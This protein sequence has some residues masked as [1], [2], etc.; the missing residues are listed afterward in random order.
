MSIY[1][2]KYTNEASRFLVFDG[3]LVHYRDEG[4]G[5]V[6]L[7]IHGA[8]SS[9]HTF[10]QW[11]A[12][13][14]NSFRIIRIDLPGFG[15]SQ[16]RID[17]KYD[18][19]T[20]IRCLNTVLKLLDVE[21]CSVAGSSLGG[22]LAWEF[23]LEQPQKVD[24]LILIDSAGFLDEKSIPLPFRMARTPFVNKI[25]RYII[26]KNVLEVFLRQVYGDSSK[27]TPELV[28]R[29]YDLFSREGNPEAFF[30]L[31]NGKFKDN[32]HQLSHI[33]APTL[34]MWGEKDE[35]LPVA[36][37]YR[38][39]SEIPQARMIIYEDLGHIPMEEDPH[40]TAIDAKAF[41]LDITL[42]EAEKSVSDKSPSER[43]K[44]D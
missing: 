21:S 20:Y 43:T 8:F 41:L 3:T 34:I 33:K 25:V 26:K 35:W 37:G 31:V 36:N 2:Q 4:E 12:E 24:K 42:A 16:A 7:L 17:H 23:A 28:D 29:Y 27:I 15:L 40:H 14:K 10:D 39:L 1:L 11:V 19:D 22:W 13:L 5:P 44:S 6:L 38:F 18:V 32:T 30:A 9:L